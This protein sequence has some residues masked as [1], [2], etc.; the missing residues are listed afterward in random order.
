MMRLLEI[1]SVVNFGRTGKIVSDLAEY[2]QH[3]GAEVLV[4]YGRGEA[5]APICPISHWSWQI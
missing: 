3:H 1:N 2:A 5:E 4:C